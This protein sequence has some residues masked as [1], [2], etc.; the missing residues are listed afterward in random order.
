MKKLAVALGVCLSL[1][2]S[3]FGTERLVTR[4][5]KAAGKDT[6]KVTKYSVKETGKVVK[7]LL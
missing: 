3:S 7:F 5:A 6:Y 2:L 1:S 4:S